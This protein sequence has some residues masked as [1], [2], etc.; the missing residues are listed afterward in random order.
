MKNHGPASPNF[1]A[2]S[3]AMYESCQRSRFCLRNNITKEMAQVSW[4]TVLDISCTEPKVMSEKFLEA[5][6]TYFKVIL[7][8]LRRTA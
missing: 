2:I 7:S 1:Y 4:S 6:Y 5:L 8:E 3:Y